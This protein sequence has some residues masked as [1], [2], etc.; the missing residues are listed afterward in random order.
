MGFYGNIT[1]TARTQFQFDKIYPNRVEMERARQ[2]DSI[3][4]GRYVLIE[5]DGDYH[6]DSYLRVWFNNQTPT[7]AYTSDDYESNTSL[8]NSDA[9]ENPVVVM[10]GET[11]DLFYA[12]K[13][14]EEYD[15]IED[16]SKIAVYNQI[17]SSNDLPY[18]VNY[19]VDLGAY[20]IARGYDST[21]WQKV[22]SDGIERYVMIAELNTVVPTFDVAADAPTMAP[23]TPH[24][25][26][27]STDVYYKLHWQAPWGFRVAAADNNTTTGGKSDAEVKWT[28]VTYDPET[29]IEETST[30]TIDGAIYFNKDGF[31]WQSRSYVEGLSKDD[32]YIKIVPTGVSGNQYNKHD[33]TADTVEKP[34]IQELTINLPTIGNMMSDAWD[35]IHGPKRDDSMAE[36]ELNEDGS[37]KIGEDGKPI[38]ID[39]LQGRLN[40]IAALNDDEIPVKRSSD[41]ALIGAT[42]NGGKT[43]N[44]DLTGKND[45]AWIETKVNGNIES[46]TIKHTF[47]SVKNTSSNSDINNNGDKI[48]LYTPIVDATG[49]VV[50]KNTETVTLPFGFKSITIGNESDKTIGVAAVA[51]SVVADNTQDTLT[52]NP[53]NKWIHI[54]AS[55]ANDENTVIISHEVNSIITTKNNDT[56]LNNGTDTI[57]IQDIQYDN[58]G[59][60]THNQSHKYTL[61][62]GYKTFKDSETTPGESIASSTQDIMILKGDNW[63]KPTISEGLIKIDHIGPVAVTATKVNDVTPKFGDTFTITDW[64]FDDKG[65]KSSSNTH[66]VTIPKGSLK[67]IEANGADVITQLT[68]VDSTGDLSTSRTNISNLKLTNYSKKTDNSD[69]AATDALGDALSKIQT[70]IHDR[71]TEITNE[72]KAR[73]EAEDKIASDLA[74]EIARADA[75]EKQVLVDAKAYTD[76]IKKE[77]LTGEA[78]ETLGDTYDTL[79]EISKWINGEGVNAGELSLAIAT[80]TDRA[81]TME[82]ILL[83]KVE[84]IEDVVDTLP[85]YTLTTGTANGTVKFNDDEVSVA[86]LGTAAYRDADEFAIVD[87]IIPVVADIVLEENIFT[88]PTDSEQ[89]QVEAGDKV[90]LLYI[91]NDLYSEINDLKD[92]INK[93]KNQNTPTE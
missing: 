43:S 46:I 32:N 76:A 18:T 87:D 71:A 51:G 21:V 60:I 29:G 35:I 41:G 92:Q 69:I 36:F 27:R 24:F 80:E 70:Q 93:L 65:H 57:T 25:D 45:D 11:E 72:A 63:V 67:D 68:F 91:I 13:K 75:A 38:R 23:I 49:H 17:V 20:E 53:G 10:Y 39:S 48:D 83:N 54:G 86:G 28:S 3:Y 19:A 26:T 55:D 15:S 37:K 2:T 31:D 56:N 90:N 33:G 22:Y 89:D 81:Q 84:A 12:W 74:E 66:T 14:P 59:H 62:F 77:I 64:Y 1:N 16:G 9:E 34:D 61:P 42:I 7:T 50:G 6:R 8:K 79:L 78:N 47:N 82:A 44:S 73:K 4:L 52:I 40:S 30:D 58:A 5:Y 88:D 85:T